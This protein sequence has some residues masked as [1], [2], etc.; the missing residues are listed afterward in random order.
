MSLSM[1]FSLWRWVGGKQHTHTNKK[2]LTVVEIGKSNQKYDRYFSIF[3]KQDFHFSYDCFYFHHFLL[4]TWCY[5]CLCC[6]NSNYF[7][8]I[9]FEPECFPWHKY[10]IWKPWIK[11]PYSSFLYYTLAC[12]CIFFKEKTS[13]ESR[14]CM[15]MV[16]SFSKGLTRLNIFYYMQSPSV[17]F[18]Q[19]IEHMAPHQQLV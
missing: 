8:S 14:I 9:P 13:S 3:L 7:V 6:R 1:F 18:G 11:Q 4:Q 12:S 2:N 10:I 15:P 16:S 5:L 17:M 19:E